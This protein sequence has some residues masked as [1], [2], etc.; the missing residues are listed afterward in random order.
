MT[1]LK[2]LFEPGKIGTLE[3]R[4]RIVMPPMQSRTADEDYHVS[5]RMVAYYAERAKGGVGLI[6]VQQSFCWPEGS[7]IRGIGLWDDSF[8]PGMKK[9]ASGVHKFGAKIAFQFGGRGTE[10]DPGREWVAPSVIPHSMDHEPPRELTKVDID[11]YVESYGEAG[12]RVKTAGFDAIEIHGAHGH[13][14]SQFLSPYT[15]RRQD[16]YGG[17]LENRTRFACRI[18]A[19][20]RQRV[21]PDFPLIFRM[22]GDDFLE[23]GITIDDAIQQA[24]IFIKAGVNALHVSGS[25]HERMWWHIPPFTFPP[26]NLVHLASVVKKAVDVPIIAVGKIGDPILAE[27]ILKEGKADFVAMGRALIADPDLPNKAKE[28]RFDDI[29]RCLYCENCITW[30]QRPRLRGR[31]MSCTVNQ[32]VAREKEFIIKRAL[33]PKNVMVAGGGL[34][35]MEAARVLAE[36]GHRVTLYEKSDKLGGQW[37]VA[38]QPENKEDYKRLVPYMSRVMEKAGVTVKLST[39]VS[40]QLVKKEKPDAVIVAT[41]A[42]P[43]GLDVDGG[44]APFVVQANDVI[45]GKAKVGERVVVV[46]GR[47]LGMEVACVLAE[48]GKHVSLVEAVELG[49]GTHNFIRAVLRDRLVE[50][51]VY[52]YPQSPV[53]RITKTGVDVANHHSLLHLKADTVVLAAGVKP[54]NDLVTDL[55]GVGVDIYS[56]GD[57]NEPRDAMEAM[58]EGAEIARRI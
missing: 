56:V 32:A 18:I 53:L 20:I 39:V 5:D 35:G 45:M 13:L 43:R 27:H 23:G 46:G 11:R 21:G 12:R 38:A 54:V 19:A 1:K 3:L 7:S 40:R 49:R 6:I 16:E 41:G 58:N 51:G 47:Y 25:T 50:L 28:G 42:V 10:Q 17:S 37:N 30:S 4:N 48:K 52:V 22:N 26:A 36:R 55:K 14:I 29:R 24:H 2:K 31:G 33:S 57:C 44:D 15:N 34:A 8:I 9:L